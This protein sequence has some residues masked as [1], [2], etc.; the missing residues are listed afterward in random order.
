MGRAWKTAVAGA[1]MA[2]GTMALAAPVGAAPVG[3]F[4]GTI[5]YTSLDGPGNVV[6]TGAISDTGV[7]VTTSSRSVGPDDKI[8]IDLDDLVLSNGTIHVKDIGVTTSSSFDTGTCTFTSSERGTFQLVGGDGAYAGIKGHGQFAVTASIQFPSD[9][10]G[11][12]DMNAQ[13]TGAIT[14]TIIGVAK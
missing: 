7:D 5:T 6:L 1:A 13:P 4:Q 9:G 11:G 8:S 14:V 12:C 2:L 3:G 10:N